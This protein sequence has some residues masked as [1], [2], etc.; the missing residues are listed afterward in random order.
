MN[1]SKRTT[2]AGAVTRKAGG[3]S[4]QTRGEMR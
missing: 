4:G 2:K 3:K 1:N